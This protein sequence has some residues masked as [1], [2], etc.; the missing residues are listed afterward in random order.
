MRVIKIDAPGETFCLLFV[1]LNLAYKLLQSPL[2][3]S[4]NVP[5]KIC[6]HSR[7][8]F[9][10]L[11]DADGGASYDYRFESS[12]QRM[13]SS[14]WERCRALWGQMSDINHANEMHRRILLQLLAW[15]YAILWIFT[16][17]YAQTHYPLNCR[18]TGRKETIMS[19]SA[20]LV[21]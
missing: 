8:L 3:G 21:I 17:W 6:W 10:Q 14:L 16:A 12:F 19:V 11:D 18:R 20:L 4:N 15:A 7:C 9:G 13:M 5:N 2:E 1:R